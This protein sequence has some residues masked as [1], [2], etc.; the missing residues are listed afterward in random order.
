MKKIIAPLLLAVLVLVSFTQKNKYPDLEDGIYAEIV[1]NKGTMVAELF[2]EDAPMTVANFVALAEG[3][4][5]LMGKEYK[6][7]PFY[8][9]LIFH[10]VIE[11]FMIQGG[12][13]T[14]TGSG[15]IGYKFPQEVREDLKHDAP[16]VLS[17]ANA[18]PNTNGSQFFIM[19]KATTSLDMKYNVFGKVIKNVEVVEAIATVERNRSDRPLEDVFMNEI[20][21]IRVGRTARK[22]KADK[23]FKAAMEN[24]EKK[25]EVEAKKMAALKANAVKAR[26]EKAVEFA[27]FQPKSLTLTSGVQFYVRK[28]G[29]GEKPVLNAPIEVDYSG[30]FPDG[31]LF[32][33]SSYDVSL[34]F[35]NHKPNRNEL[36]YK[37]LS[38]NYNTSMQ[39]IPGFKEAILTMGY[40]DEFVVFIPPSQGYGSRGAGGSIPPNAD[41]V[42]EIKILPKK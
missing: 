32:D 9:G 22:W 6:K 25:E 38:L 26:E 34:K 15:D 41:L 18:G 7:K 36:S 1:T 29:T 30:F 40:G 24:Y 3:N 13:K 33:S 19:H 37:P 2:Y 14:G 20:N 35:D 27:S 10:R 28:S 17:M 31:R 11:N 4:H 12:D 42:F 23:V 8:N 5:P 39:L 16:G 21:I